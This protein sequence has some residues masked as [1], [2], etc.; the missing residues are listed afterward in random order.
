M[1][2]FSHRVYLESQRT[3]E[4]TQ[5]A[6]SL[7]RGWK[8]MG[9]PDFL[10]ID[11]ALSFH[12][13]NTYPRSFGTVIKTCLHFGVQP[14]FIPVGEPWRNGVIESF[15]DT[16]NKN[17]FRRQWFK[18]Y[19]HLKHQSKNFQRF[20]NKHHRYSC[21]QG[22]TP[23][24]CTERYQFRPHRLGPNTKVPRLDYIPDG[25]IILIRFIRSDRTLDIF[26]EK[27][28]VPRELI[29]SYVKAVIV[30]QIHALLVYQGEQLVLTLGY[31]LPDQ[32]AFSY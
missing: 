10:Q 13:S 23:D 15:N 19:A 21:L 18:S 5:V 16:Y 14:V 29:Y 31:Q 9:L 27:F 8:A 20:H 6:A 7:L 3:K 22:K 4:D 30:T 32:N 24:E 25:T 11:N 28:I 1:D 12:G 17:F 2:L 26:G